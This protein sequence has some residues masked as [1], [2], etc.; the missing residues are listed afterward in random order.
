MKMHFCF[1][2]SVFFPMVSKFAGLCGYMGEMSIL[3]AFTGSQL[4]LLCKLSNAATLQEIADIAYFL[5]RN[6]IFITD[7]SHTILAYTRSVEIHDELWQRT[8]VKEHFEGNVLRQNHEIGI[9]HNNSFKKRCPVMVEDESMPFPRLVKVLVDEERPIGVVVVPGLLSPI[10][11]GDLQLLE[12]ISSFVA[13]RAQKDHYAFINARKSV[14]NILIKLLDGAP[15]TADY[16][17]KRLESLEWRLL[18]YQYVLVLWFGDDYREERTDISSIINILTGISHCRAFLYNN[19]ITF[20]YSCAQPVSDWSTQS[21]ELN[22]VLS[23]WGLV[24]GISRRFSGIEKLREHYLQAMTAHW[25]GKK[26]G[27]KGDCMCYDTLSVYHML[28]QVSRTAPLRMFCHKKVLDLEE[29]DQSGES[30]LL[31]T[32]QVY[33]EHTKSLAK[34]A[35]ILFLHR[36]TIRYRINK[37]MEVMDS[38]FTDNNDVFA[39]MLSLR[40]L[41]YERKL[42]QCQAIKPLV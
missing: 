16:V 19:A 32:L 26:L 40:I 5:L 6:P 8:V 22:S 4:E 29:F 27:R 39:Y 23:K 13:V 18:P 37:C 21:A 33:L 12:L 41:E 20:V 9:V 31:I 17:A 28:E 11:E 7:M 30:K 35:E 24:T 1:M 15:M 10:A 36:N 34:T 38:D 2:Q 25:L 3:D 14:N 42:M